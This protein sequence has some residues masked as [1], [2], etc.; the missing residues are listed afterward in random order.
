MSDEL[1]NERLDRKKVEEGVRL[2]LEGIGEDMH[3]L[4][5]CVSISGLCWW[6]IC[7][8]L[9]RERPRRLEPDVGRPVGDLVADAVGENAGMATAL[10]GRPPD[11]PPGQPSATRS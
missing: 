7:P 5:A 4:V 11:Q 1:R 10:C 8:G 6:A 3:A 2:I 9:G